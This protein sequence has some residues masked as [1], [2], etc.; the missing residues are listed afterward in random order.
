MTITTKTGD[1]GVTGLW[2]GSRVSKASL[3]I[4]AIGSLDELNSALGIAR[5]QIKD[6][7]TN[8]FLK[9]CQRACFVIGAE[10]ASLKVSQA[11]KKNLPK[12]KNQDIKKLESEIEKL[13][14]KLPVLKNFI[15]PAGSKISS[16]LFFVRTIA[17]RA[18]RSV[19][20]LNFASL[21]NS[22]KL[23]NRLSDFLFL[24]ARSFN[25]T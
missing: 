10:I 11:Q 4:E 19:V 22:Q 9:F 24:L 7:K 23:L 20:R 17:R 1:A 5:A 8:Q 12:I 14:K 16:W 25:R 15:F 6:Q 3:E 21:K 2:G 13:E 18:E